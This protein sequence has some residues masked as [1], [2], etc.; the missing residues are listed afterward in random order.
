M[1]FIAFSFGYMATFVSSDI[2]IPKY[3]CANV[4]VFQWTVAFCNK[5]NF[6]I[7][8]KQEVCRWSM[9]TAN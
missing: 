6:S 8:E 1:Y 7:Q 5:D 4:A 2:I 9:H 3:F